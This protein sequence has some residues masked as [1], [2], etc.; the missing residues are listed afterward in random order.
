MPDGAETVTKENVQQTNGQTQTNEPSPEERLAQLI[1]QRVTDQVSKE[2]EAKVRL[3]TEQSRRE[4]QSAKDKAKAE[5]QRAQREAQ[6]LGQVLDAT[7]TQLAQDDP[8]LATRLRLLQLESTD[9]TRQV[10]EQQRQL[11]EARREAETTFQESVATIVKGLGLDPSDPKIDKAEDTP[12]FTEKMTRILSSAVAARNE[13][14]A[15]K[16][17]GFEERLKALETGKTTQTQQANKDANSVDVSSSSS[18]GDNAPEAEF[19]KKLGTGEEPLTAE[20]VKRFN[21][22]LNS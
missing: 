5:V 13:V 14:D 1:D 10:E 18:G 11:E 3:L 22:Y 15:R 12:N 6:S 16:Q 9:R 2:V 20:D 7:R 4:I 19:V 17:E 21:K 8:E